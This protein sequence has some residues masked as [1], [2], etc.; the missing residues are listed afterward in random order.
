MR[1]LLI[2]LICALAASAGAS[3]RSVIGYW[4]NPDDP[5]DTTA[6][7]PDRCITLDDHM[8]IV[9]LRVQYLSGK[10]AVGWLGENVV[11]YHWDG[12]ILV[13]D[14]AKTP[15][16]HRVAAMP[17]SLQGEE[18]T[19]PPGKPLDAARVAAIAQ[20]LGRRR[21]EDQAVRKDPSRRGDMGR[22]DGDN[23][24]WIKK[25]VQEIGWL[26]ATRFGTVS[27]NTAFLIVQHS[28]DLALMQAALPRIESD[29]T[30]KVCDPQDFALLYD[31]VAT[32]NGRLQRYGSQVGQA[33]GVAAVFPL[34]DRER[35]DERRRSIGLFPM[36][37][38]LGLMKQ[39]TGQAPVYMDDLDKVSAPA[40]Q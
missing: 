40:R 21:E 31:R 14:A 16:W 4:E 23:T 18:L 24:A 32:M 3:E 38:Y 26:D 2:P 33:N 12:E 7:E 8:N 13:I 35:V 34:E 19:I 10:F 9:Y 22:I 30:K 11:S 37:T 39:I 5:T 36:G 17:K 20:E 29:F 6:L 27:A 28:G 25:L 15:H 1:S